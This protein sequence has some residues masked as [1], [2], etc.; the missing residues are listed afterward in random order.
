MNFV[1][2]YFE[3]YSNSSENLHT[4]SIINLLELIVIECPTCLNDTDKYSHMCAMKHT[5]KN[6]GFNHN[7]FDFP[8]EKI[9]DLCR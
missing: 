1:Y 9:N 5:C 4:T 6:N 3:S 8:E 2:Q 7:V